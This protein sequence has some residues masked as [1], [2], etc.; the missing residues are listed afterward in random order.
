MILDTN[1]LS[2]VADGDP[3]IEPILRNAAQIAI[4]VIVLGEYRYGI[5]QSRD[6]NRYEQWLSEYLPKFRILDIDE[7]TTISYASVRLELKKAGTPIPS[8]DVWI[9]ALCRQHSLP[10]V[11]RDRHFDA[12]SG[13]KRLHW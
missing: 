7:R 1:G 10:V 5:S 8:N 6:R 11:S 4:P 13:I 3:T 12:V 2:A 9:A